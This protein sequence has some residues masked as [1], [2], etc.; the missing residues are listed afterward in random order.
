[1][2]VSRPRSAMRKIRE[3]LRLSHAEG[4]SRR[5]VGAA[6]GL[7]YTT[8]ANHLDRARRAGLGWPLP[9]GLDE[10][11]LEARLFA[12]AAPPPS[13][14]RALPE[15]PLVQRELR[16]PGVTLQ[17]LHMEYKERQP[18][19]YQ[20]TQFCDLYRR[21]QGHLDVVMRQEHRAGE[22]LFVDFPGQTIPI[23]DPATGEIWRA[24][25]FVAVLGASNYTYAEALPSQ[26]LPHWIAGHVAAFGARADPGDRS[27]CGGAIG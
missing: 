11:E 6:L 15:W 22:K 5:Q 20:Y 9:E 1:M 17:L 26:A 25:L 27:C 24:E 14:S 7:P 10:V 8:V 18:D 13:H 23:V 12:S 16:R 19:G 3:I 4:L 2:P 21:W